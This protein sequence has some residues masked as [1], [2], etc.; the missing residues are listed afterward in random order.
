MVSILNDRFQNAQAVAFSNISVSRV[1]L[2]AIS[3]QYAYFR[4]LESLFNNV[5]IG[6]FLGN[7]PQTLR[8]KNND[9]MENENDDSHVEDVFWNVDQIIGYIE[10]MLSMST[11]IQSSR[12]C[13]KDPI[14]FLTLQPATEW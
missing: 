10:I 12:L 6:I 3:N 13:I 14:V 11:F 4:R 1:E 5:E 8:E 7:S 2:V 9:Q